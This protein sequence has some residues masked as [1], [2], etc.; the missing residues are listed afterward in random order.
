MDPTSTPETPAEPRD[1]DDDDFEAPK[2]GMLIVA[3]VVAL[4]VGGMAGFAIGFK[5]EQNRI[6]SASKDKRD[7]AAA[8]NQGGKGKAQP[9][10]E[11]T[12]A[13]P[14]SITIRTANGKSRVINIS[15]ST[16]IEK[17][18]QG[19]PADIATGAKVIVEGKSTS[20]GDFD[21]T[22]VVVLPADSKLVKDSAG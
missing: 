18:S 8:R 20:G 14:T 10:G 5:V 2:L 1:D 19:A 17:V 11:V 9:S 4:A 15:A 13:S 22:E 21:A 6:K 16:V 12:Q 7:V 3:A